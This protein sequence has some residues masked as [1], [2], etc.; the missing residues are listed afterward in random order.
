MKKKTIWIISILL[1]IIVV[2][3]VLQFLMSQIVAPILMGQEVNLPPAIILI[4][5][6]IAG[7]FF[8]FLGLLLSVPLAAIIVVLVREIYIKDILGDHG[9]EKEPLMEMV[10]DSEPARSAESNQALS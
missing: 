6:I 3:Y 4:S 7:I 2:F 9:P 5:Q 1:L 8:G 10:V